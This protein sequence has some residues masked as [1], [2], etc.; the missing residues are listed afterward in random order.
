MAKSMKK[1]GRGRPALPRNERIRTPLNMRV[2]E[3]FAAAAEA[4]QAKRKLDTLS[5]AVRTA[6]EETFK[7]EGLLKP[8]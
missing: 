1:R 7:R 2:S 8:R 6:A 3:D 5:S 4:Y